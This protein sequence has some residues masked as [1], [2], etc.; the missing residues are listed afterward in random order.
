MRV[1]PA[2]F[3]TARL[4]AE[5]IGPQHADALI[6]LNRDER[7]MRWIH[8]VATDTETV[9]SIGEKVALWERYGFGH[10]VLFAVTEASAANPDDAGAT[11]AGDAGARPRRFAG[12]AGLQHCDID[13]VDEVELLYALQFECWG[14]G[15]ATEAGRALLDI[16]FDRL[17]LASI[18]AY[19]RLDNRRS[20]HVIEKL[21]FAYERDI[22]HVGEPYSLFRLF[23]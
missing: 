14:R 16:A 15:Y 11:G 9:E 8:G 7:V 12:R 19:A 2:T 3:R 17:G 21:G 18:V 1:A 20:R 5:R 4:I 13:G 10:W 23:R 6:E 22:E